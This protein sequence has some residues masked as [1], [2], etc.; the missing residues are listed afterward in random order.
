MGFGRNSQ[1]RFEKG[2]S[3]GTGRKVSELRKSFVDAIT[4]EDVQAIVQAVI[5]K[6]K[7]GDI[8]AVQIIL[9]YT[10]GAP[11]KQDELR[12]EICI[13]EAPPI[14]DPFHFQ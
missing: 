12:K 13:D 9:P 4:P 1:G 6:A 11:L 2:N 7:D 14:P 10:I 5:Q 3:F 8:K